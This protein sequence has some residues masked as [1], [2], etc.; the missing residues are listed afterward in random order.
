MPHG[1][2]TFHS[3]SIKLYLTLTTQIEGIKVE[4]A[5]E[6]PVG[7]ESSIEPAKDLVSLPAKRLRGRPR[8]H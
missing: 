4:P 6:E 5:N 3:T 2:T 7:K 1:N 8:K